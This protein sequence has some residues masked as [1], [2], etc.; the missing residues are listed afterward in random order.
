MTITTACEQ[1][2]EL[3]RR[4]D[5]PT[6]ARLVAQIVQELAVE[7]DVS[8]HQHRSTQQQGCEAT[9]VDDIAR[10]VQFTL[11]QHGKTTAVVLTPDLWRQILDALEDMEDQALVRALQ[12][13]IAAGPT[14]TGALRWD[15]VSRDWT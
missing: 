2:L 9:T 3:V 6:R 15:D 13:R 10:N 1:A 5:R 7:P 11:D 12:Q 4:L 8:H 14:A